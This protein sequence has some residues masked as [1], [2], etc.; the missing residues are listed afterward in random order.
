MSISIHILRCSRLSLTRSVAKKA[1]N[2]AVVLNEDGIFRAVIHFELI[3]ELTWWI[4]TIRKESQHANDASI[5]C[6]L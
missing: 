1:Q 6:S 2:Y 3:R 4:V 5:Y